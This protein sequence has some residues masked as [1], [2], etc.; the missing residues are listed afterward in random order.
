M[1]ENE[2]LTEE[3]GKA[4]SRVCVAVAA[5]ALAGCAGVHLHDPGRL[6]AAG[7]ATEIAKAFSSEG[8][9]VFETLSYAGAR[10]S[11]E[12]QRAKTKLATLDS[13]VGRLSQ[14]AENAF[15][16]VTGID[17]SEAGHV[18]MVAKTV[19]RFRASNTVVTAKGVVK[20]DGDQIQLG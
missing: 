11:A 3:M 4:S 15:R 17:R 10:V 6:K 13:V 19:M 8:T 5:L 20:V 14:R 7:E 2:S 1:Y 9:A 16:R 18:D 12:V